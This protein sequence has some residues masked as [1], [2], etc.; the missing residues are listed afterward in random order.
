M[1]ADTITVRPLAPALGAEVLDIDLAAPLDN[2]TVDAIHR[3]FLDHQ[4]LF[5]HDQTL[6]PED[7]KAFAR[8]FGELDTHPYAGHLPG[9]SE[10]VEVLKEESDTWNFGG[11][12]HTDVSFLEA[13]PLGSVL[14]A[15]EVPDVGGDTLWANMYLA[16]E[17]LSPGMR[18]MLDELTCIH[19]PNGVF[20][21]GKEGPKGQTT[22]MAIGASPDD[23][24][25]VEHPLVR[26][27]PQTGRKG[28]FGGGGYLVRFKDMTVEESR[29]L[30]DFLWRHATR[31]EFSCR[32]RWRAGDV[33][34]WDNRCTMHYAL[35]DYHG[36]RRLMHRVSIRGDRPA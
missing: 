3:A 21:A 25:E 18:R 1:T 17:A 26:T 29:P 9:H 23:A 22:S 34:L 36:H 16:Y 31:E 20:G 4:V 5:F 33:A 19:S 15:R 6:T 13:P 11:V 2:R 24:V 14:Y 30:M 32:F 27:H 7:H 10:I 35:N 28:L 12:W 8:R